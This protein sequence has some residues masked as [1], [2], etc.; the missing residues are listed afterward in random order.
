M[1]HSFT[2]NAE[3]IGDMVYDWHINCWQK[4]SRAD[5]ESSTKHNLTVGTE[6]INALDLWLTLKSLMK[7]ESLPIEKR[8]RN[9]VSQLTLK[10]PV[11]M[12]YG[13]RRNHWK[14]LSCC[15]LGIVNATQFHSW[16]WNRQR[17]W[18]TANTETVSTHNHTFNV[19]SFIM[20]NSFTQ[21]INQWTSH[22][23]I[24]S[25]I[26]IVPL[27]IMQGL[28]IVSPF[29]LLVEH[30]CPLAF[31]LHMKFVIIFITSIITTT[32][33]KHTFI[34][35]VHNHEISSITQ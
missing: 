18:F 26:C 5:S 3:I 11:H 14:K 6:I 27:K 2:A 33:Y 35:L 20:R 19:F 8:Q 1:Q 10:S 15:W 29:F 12:V 31:K 28:F 25:I 22:K 17:I 34:H 7:T 32:C 24:I 30:C 21:P 23:D 9:T 16:R 4:L 13:W